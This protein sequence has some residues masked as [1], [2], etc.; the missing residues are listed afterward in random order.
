M[1]PDAPPAYDDLPDELQVAIRC[2]MIAAE[3][4]WDSNAARYIEAGW[5]TEGTHNYI[6][7]RLEALRTMREWTGLVGLDDLVADRMEQALALPIAEA[8]A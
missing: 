6:A 5:V 2:T 7:D 3:Y 4:Q 1:A 8:V